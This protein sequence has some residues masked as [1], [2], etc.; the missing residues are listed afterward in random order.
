M[1]VGNDENTVA[2]KGQD[3]IFIGSTFTLDKAV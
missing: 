1:M 3:P 2:K